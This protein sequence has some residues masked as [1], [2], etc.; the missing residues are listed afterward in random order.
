MV[1]EH[2][3]MEATVLI[4]ALIDTLWHRCSGKWLLEQKSPEYTRTQKNLTARQLSTCNM[5]SELLMHK[6]P[7]DL[8]WEHGDLEL[9]S[10]PCGQSTR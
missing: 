7:N 1:W 4:K 2:S 6:L 3:M 9:Y 10:L 5:M 8:V